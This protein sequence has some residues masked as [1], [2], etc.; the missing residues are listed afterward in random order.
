MLTALHHQWVST[1][2][3]GGTVHVLAIDIAGAFDQVSHRGLFAK[4]RS[5]GIHSKLLE[6]LESYLSNHSLEVVVEGQT[7]SRYPIIADVPQGSCFG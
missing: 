2:V 7:S 6:W 4:F 5:Y 1:M 3:T